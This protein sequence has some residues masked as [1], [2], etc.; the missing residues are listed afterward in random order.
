MIIELTT[1]AMLSDT[2]LLNEVKRLTAHERLATARLVGALG[3]LDARRL[4]LAEGC[5]SLFVYCTRILHLSEHAA[6]LRIEAARAARKWPAILEL[7]AEGALHLTAIGLLAPHLTADNVEAALTAARHQSKREVEEIVAA[8]R[9][10]PAVPPSVRRLPVGKISSALIPSQ[11]HTQP[12]DRPCAEPAARQDIAP[13][14]AKARDAN[15]V[16]PLAPER[17]RVQLTI[18]RQTQQQPREAQDLLRHAVPDGDIAVIFERALSLLLIDLHK[19]RHAD[20]Q[21]PRSTPSAAEGAGMFPP[22]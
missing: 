5:S 11:V 2:E 6:Y 3:E 22:P 14:C 18:S 21:R 12:S 15:D 17:F 8:L 7:L 10:R 4:Y 13:A 9:P 1:T 19:T 16:R 20:V